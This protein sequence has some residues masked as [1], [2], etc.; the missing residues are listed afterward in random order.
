MV[1]VRRL[2]DMPLVRGERIIV[3]ADLDV[4]VKNGKI[5]EAYRL[6]ANVDTIVSFIRRG[7]NV[8]IVGHRG[9]PGGVAR[10]AFSLDPVG[11]WFSHILK[12]PVTMVRDP[13]SE[14]AFQRFNGSPEVLLFEN[15]RFWKGEEGQSPG[16][17]KALSRWGDYYVNEA[18]AA[19]HRAHASLV[20]LPRLLPSFA[21]LHL[22]REVEALDR[23]VPVRA[24]PFVA[25]LGGA[26]LETKL[27][28]VEQ[29]IKFADRVLVGGALANTLLA[30]RGL[31]VGKS[32]RDDGNLKK[33][34]RL[35]LHPKVM[36]PH[37][38]IVARS[39]TRRGRTRVIAVADI[40]RDEMIGDVGPKTVREFVL[41]VERAGTAVWNGPL[42]YSEI[43]A[44]A[45]SI[46]AVARGFKRCRG[47]TV[48]GGGDTL[49]ALEKAKSLGAFSHVSTGGGAM[50]EYLA[51][52]KLPGIEA[53][54]SGGGRH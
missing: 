36:L 43:P 5:R 38:V 41:A 31:C 45:R 52:K 19:S 21:G 46:P 25:L 44:F 17:A 30:A 7:G 26:K 47:F 42:G 50:L 10:P 8:R 20:L 16:F 28:L 40:G 33:F 29:F 23:I 37:D 18:F 12:I 15:L 2:K 32:T 24:R 9:R 14:R 1:K 34:R 22:V 35:A 6:E 11:K 27:P 53:L 48:V 4:P 54:K 49:A 13:Y 39:L 3:R 51:G